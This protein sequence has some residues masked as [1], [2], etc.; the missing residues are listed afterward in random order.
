[1]IGFIIRR[2]NWFIFT[3]LLLAIITIALHTLFLGPAI[4]KRILGTSD[5]RELK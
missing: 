5:S 2:N 4:L 1:M 3:G